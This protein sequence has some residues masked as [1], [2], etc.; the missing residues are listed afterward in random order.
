VAKQIPKYI[1]E[2]Q[3]VAERDVD[4]IRKKD[5]SYGGSWKKRGGVGAFMMVARKWD[6][7][8]TLVQKHGYDVFAVV[9]AEELDPGGETL[10]DTIRDLRA[11]LILI[12]AEMIAQG[13]VKVEE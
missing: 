11:Y 7:L 8:E 3:G 2:I 10:I 9:K 13:V 5:K 6:R 4:M 12:E 1:D